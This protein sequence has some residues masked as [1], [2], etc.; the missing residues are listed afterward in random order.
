MFIGDSR[1]DIE[2]GRAAGVR[3]AAALWGP[4]DRAHLESAGPD[5]WLTT[6]ADI[7]MLCEAPDIRRQT[8]DMIDE[9]TSDV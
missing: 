9:L 5:F 8:S 2:C 7:G 6:P 1:H 3:T 4:F